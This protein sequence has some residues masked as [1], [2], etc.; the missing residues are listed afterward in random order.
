MLSSWG[1]D[2]EI[3]QLNISKAPLMISSDLAR[4]LAAS[5]GWRE[6]T[7]GAFSAR[8][9]LVEAAW[10]QAEL[11]GQR[12]STVQLASLVTA[13]AKAPVQLKGPFVSRPDAVRFAPDGL[14]KGYIIDAAFAAAQRASPGVR[15]LKVDIGGDLR[16]GGVAPTAAGWSVGV[17]GASPADNA[18]PEQ[19]LALS[20]KAVATSGMGKR[21]RVIAGC[22]YSQTLSPIDGSAV[23]TPEVTVVADRAADADA[24]ASALSVMPLKAGLA[25]MERTSGAEARIVRTDGL[26][27]TTNGW[28]G[29]LRPASV[30]STSFA[31]D[32]AAPAAIKAWPDGFG[33]TI[34]YTIPQLND[35]R[36]PP[37]IA[38]W[39]TDSDGKMVRTLFHLGDNPRAS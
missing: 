4:V 25:L 22:A 38:I 16:C 37:F 28:T 17:G 6:Q 8:L 12:P 1:S 19:V 26:A 11:A 2:S 10:N 24:L 21:D 27:V 34:G 15:G 3:S 39:I 23:T 5:E 36:H 33:V 35:P 9:G 32:C 13:A 14:A 29:L 20:G 18:A 31:L 30:S 7:G